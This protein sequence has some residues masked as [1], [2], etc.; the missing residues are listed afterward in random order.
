MAVSSS[1]QIP[2][3][4]KENQTLGEVGIVF[5]KAHRNIILVLPP[6]TCKPKVEK[7]VSQQSIPTDEQSEAVTKTDELNGNNTQIIP[8]A[9]TSEQAVD[10][11][12]DAPVKK[13]IVK[14]KTLKTGTKTVKIKSEKTTTVTLDNG[15]TE[16]KKKVVKKQT[17]TTTIQ[18][19]NGVT[20]G[21][22][23]EE[24]T[25]TN[26]IHTTNGDHYEEKNVTSSKSEVIDPVLIEQ[27]SLSDRRSSSTDIDSESISEKNRLN[28]SVNGF[29]EKNLRRDRSAS[30][31]EVASY[32]FVVG[33]KN[34]KPKPN[35]ESESS[36]KS[37]VY[38]SVESQPATN[39]HETN[40]T[41]SELEKSQDLHAKLEVNRKESDEQITSDSISH[42]KSSERSATSPARFQI[43]LN[44]S[45]TV[46]PNQS[47]KE[48][49][50]PF[51]RSEVSPARFT[52]KLAKK[53]VDTE[54]E[55]KK[56]VSPAPEISPKEEVLAT[57]EISEPEVGAKLQEEVI[58]RDV[59]DAKVGP[60]SEI[61]PSKDVTPAVEIDPKVEINHTQIDTV[62]AV[63][64]ESPANVETTK[65]E[66]VPETN[67]AAVE[68]VAPKEKVTAKTELSTSVPKVKI[69]RKSESGTD[70]GVKTVKSKIG[71]KVEGD[72]EISPKAE[73]GLKEVVL[74]KTKKIVD[75]KVAD[76]VNG[77]E[78]TTEVKKKLVKKV[79]DPASTTGEVVKKK[80]VKKVIG[81][82]AENG[83]GEVV[84]KVIKKK[85]E[86]STAT[87]AAPEI[88]VKVTKKKVESV[89]TD[90]EVDATDVQPKPNNIEDVKDEEPE[91]PATQTEP[92]KL[93]DNKLEE[94]KRD[95]KMDDDQN[96]QQNDTVDKKEFDPTLYLSDGLRKDS[97]MMGIDDDLPV[98]RN[99]QKDFELFISTA[100]AQLDLP[101][102][103]SLELPQSDK[104]RRDVQ[105]LGMD[106][107]LALGAS[108]SP[109]ES[110]NQKSSN[111]YIPLAICDTPSSSTDYVGKLYSG[112]SVAHISVNLIDFF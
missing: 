65:V 58:P 43:K 3:S 105:M 80:V 64:I 10:V 15:V 2:L 42:T 70:V 88:K 110:D 97:Q 93:V 6:S 94:E 57:T 74:K 54:E 47:P 56:E 27:L 101:H 112:T 62:I 111:N 78:G 31:I 22:T 36:S 100:Q 26:S 106:E 109:V 52:I 21:V 18:L 83:T 84:K 71:S 13:K 89:P 86:A 103:L 44:E 38:V 55:L 8:A 102:D 7:S 66:P 50:A 25:V 104:N 29:D 28:V 35:T 51:L 90:P 41:L 85:S 16:V 61:T 76:S 34:L 107:D 12:L 108:A 73:V 96:N 46:Q 79:K 19:P 98:G 20:N 11:K 23:S 99:V 39:S 53:K 67:N 81:A 30:P 40:G 77:T 4:L 33:K 60:T 32:N 48:V 5:K 87:D 82:T 75:G 92:E 95:T 37:N 1:F 68:V 9:D 49:S 72:N 63:D 69:V 59:V 14:V 24:C 45:S 17:D 91:K